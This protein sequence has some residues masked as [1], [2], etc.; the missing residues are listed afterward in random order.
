MVLIYFVLQPSCSLKHACFA[1]DKLIYPDARISGSEI[2][3]TGSY[4]YDDWITCIVTA[5]PV[6]TVHVQTTAVQPVYL[7]SNLPV[8]S[9]KCEAPLTKYRRALCYFQQRAALLHL[10]QQMK[11]DCDNETTFYVTETFE[12]Y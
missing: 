5:T 6:F 9:T 2:L 8:T 3:T 12:R 1:Y 4:L 11:A 10:E 7:P